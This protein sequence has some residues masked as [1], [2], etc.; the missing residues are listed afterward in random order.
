MSRLFI[1]HRT[2]YRYSAPVRFGMHRLVLRPRENHDQT[3]TS[4][5]LSFQ[6]A[7]EITWMNDV[8]GNHCAFAEFPEPAAELVIDSQ[9]T[10]DRIDKGS[11]TGATEAPQVSR[12][13][14]P[15]A[16]LH[17][18]QAVAEA[19][20]QPTYPEEH[21]EVRAWARSVIDDDIK[22]T[23]LD[24]A[25]AITIAI[26]CGIDYRRREEAGVQSPATTLRLGTGSCRDMA[27]LGMEA[28]RS[29]GIPARFVSGYLNSLSSLAGRGSTH[30]WFDAYLPDCGWWG[31]DATSGKPTTRS[32]IPIG[33]SSHPRG[34][35]PVSGKFDNSTG[36]SLGM[37]VSV[38]IRHETA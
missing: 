27:T 19:Y 4:H 25:Q 34:V 36:T 2:V 23:A 26:F 13:T 9:A 16:F 3:V 8:F 18:E 22:A 33:V 37:S 24:A 32:Q 14:L 15:L 11:D 21:A 35:M 17:S 20:L 1:H 12:M 6:P 30:A 5:R 29:L 10:L 7:A 38:A 31:F 28:L